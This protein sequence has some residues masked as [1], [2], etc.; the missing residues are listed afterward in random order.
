M[1]T[2]QNG[3]KIEPCPDLIVHNH[4]IFKDTLIFSVPVSHVITYD[5]TLT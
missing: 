1:S 3:G 4:F 2:I 5:I